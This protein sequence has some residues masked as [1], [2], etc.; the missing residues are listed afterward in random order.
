MSAVID[1]KAFNRIKSYIDYAKNN[2]DKAEIV[3]GG[4]CNDQKGYFIE[5]TCI[6]VTNLN[7]KLLTEVFLLFLNFIL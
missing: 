7:S 6:K 5:P 4:N 2:S 1:Q 3:F